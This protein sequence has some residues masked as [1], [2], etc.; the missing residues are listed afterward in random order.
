MHRPCLWLLILLLVV[1]PLL[2]QDI[3]PPLRDGQDWAMHDV[4]QHA[5]PFLAN[6]SN[7]RDYPCAWPGRLQLEAGK[8]G[9]R[10][11]LGVHVDTVSRAG[12]P[13]W[14]RWGFAAWTHGGYW[15]CKPTASPLPAADATAEADGHA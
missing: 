15:R 3:P 12:Q 14:L 7:G 9:G 8:D 1:T 13:G 6:Q 2:A 5:C 4:P 11:T 10:F